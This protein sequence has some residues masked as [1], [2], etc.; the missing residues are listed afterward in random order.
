ILA[1]DSLV[2]RHAAKALVTARPELIA[3]PWPTL[4]T[5]GELDDTA[6]GIDWQAEVDDVADWA[7]RRGLG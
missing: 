4:A 2:L 6:A 3:A 5:H 7:R 1:H